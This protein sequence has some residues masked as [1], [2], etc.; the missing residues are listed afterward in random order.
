[1]IG[2]EQDAMTRLQRLFE[3]LAATVLNRGEAVS[4]FQKQRQEW[5]EQAV[6]Q[7]V[8]TGRNEIA[9]LRDDQILHVYR[10][11]A[12]IVGQHAAENSLRIKNYAGWFGYWRI[13][14]ADRA[15]P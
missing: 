6:D 7:R 9:G 14:I 1:M 5:L 12:S 2:R 4:L 13:T 10:G 8:E 15:W 3:F 11:A